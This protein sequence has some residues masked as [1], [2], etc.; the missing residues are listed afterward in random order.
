MASTIIRTALLYF[1]VITALRIMGKRQIGDMQP[2]ELVIT[3]FISQ[4]AS[5]PIEDR[6]QPILGSIAAIF[7]LVVIEIFLSFLIMKLPALSNLVDGK[8]AVIINDGKLDQRLMK[9]MRM[10][11]ADLC[12]MLRQQQIFNIDEVGYA[13]LE[14]NGSLSVLL[15]PR[16]KNASVGDVNGNTADN[17]MP[18]AVICD[19]K[20]IKSALSKIKMDKNKLRELVKKQNIEICD[21][22]LMTVDKRENCFVIRKETS[23]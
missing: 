10:T 2:N 17:G 20:V 7:L 5:I 15:K 19:G 3:I 21:T 23:K 11:V 8:P 6:N 9:R 1:S 18:V 4:I 14:T 22:M 12:E 16:Y 13:I